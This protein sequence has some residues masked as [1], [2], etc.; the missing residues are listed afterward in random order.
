MKYMTKE[1]YEKMQKTGFHLLLKVSKE[2]EAFSEDY[3]KKLYQS[4]E[5]AW[6]QLQEDVSKV[7]FEDIFPDEFHAENIDGTPLELS[8]FEEAKKAYFEMREQSRLDFINNPAFDPEQ[9][10]KNFKQAL[11]YNVQNLKRSLPEE[12]LKKVADI[13]VLALNRASA[14]VKKE[15]SLF[16]KANKKAVEMAIKA[17]WKEH[18][19][20]FKNHEP[21]FAE[22]FHFHD[23]KVT[24]C[25]KRGSDILITLDNSG[26]FTDINQIVL[27]DCSILKQDAPLHGAWWLYEEIYKSDNGYEIHVLLQKTK[28][29]DFIVTVSNIT[30]K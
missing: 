9:E 7:K 1:W 27:K 20:N 26:G 19:K 25:R 12:I 3:F 14:D 13:R 2:A 23:C 11:R 5:K 30:Y 6:L 16:C 10:K 8:E 18:R 28:L 21:A 24:S 22:D 17:Y 29:I 15:I 4:E